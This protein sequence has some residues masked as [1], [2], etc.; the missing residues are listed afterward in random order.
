[1][2]IDLE[3]LQKKIDDLLERETDEDLKLWIKR[4]KIEFFNNPWIRSN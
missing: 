2:A 1:M 4:R 3:V